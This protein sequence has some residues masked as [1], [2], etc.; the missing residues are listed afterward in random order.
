MRSVQ[1]LVLAACLSLLSPAYADTINADLTVTIQRN[2]FVSDVYTDHVFGYSH[3]LGSFDATGSHPTLSG[4]MSFNVPGL[5]EENPGIVEFFDPR[6]GCVTDALLFFI[7]TG[8]VDLFSKA[9][10]EFVSFTRTPDLTAF[11]A[12][13]APPSAQIVSVPKTL[14]PDGNFEAIYT[15]SVQDQGVGSNIFPMNGC[16]FMDPNPCTDD[17]IL[18]QI[19]QITYVLV[20]T[21]EPASIALTSAVIIGFLG[22]RYRRMKAWKRNRSTTDC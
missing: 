20:D 10:P 5:V 13:L 1:L 21:P 8:T 18:H 16:G 9:S 22:L 3:S 7:F 4:G 19:D 11:A 6:C 17:H 14:G 12:S 2:G 15:V